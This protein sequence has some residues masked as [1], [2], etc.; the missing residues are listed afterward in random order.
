MASIITGSQK[1]M[2]CRK[3]FLL[4]NQPLNRYSC[5]KKPNKYGKVLWSKGNS[6]RLHGQSAV[7]HFSV[8]HNAYNLR[9]SFYVLQCSKYSSN[10]DSSDFKDDTLVKSWVKQMREDFDH[11]AK[12]CGV[13][14]DADADQKFINEAKERLEA[15]S[16]EQ[17]DSEQLEKLGYTTEEYLAMLKDTSMSSGQ[18]LNPSDGDE[19]N[20][21]LCSDSSS[22][23]SDSDNESSSSSSSDDDDNDQNDGDVNNSSKVSPGTRNS[24]SGKIS[25]SESKG[26]NSKDSVNF[27]D[28]YNET[29]E[30]E[31]NNKL[32]LE[33]DED[34]IILNRGDGVVRYVERTADSHK[35]N[36]MYAEIEDKIV[37]DIDDFDVGES[38]YADGTE[39][40]DSYVTLINDDEE[41]DG[42]VIDVSQVS[43]DRN[44]PAVI[45]SEENHLW[46]ELEI[47]DFVNIAPAESAVEPA[48]IP[49][50]PLTRGKSGVFDIEELITL[51]VSINA[52]DHVTIRI[53]PVYSFSDY[54][55]IVSA[56]SKR[57]LK[58]MTEDLK[59]TYKQKR[60]LGDRRYLRVEGA[61]SDW[62]AMDIG[63]I[64]V[65]MFMPDEREKYD[66]ET[67]WTV[68]AEFDP[69]CTVERDPYTYTTSDLPWLQELEDQQ[70]T[71][72]IGAHHGEKLKKEIGEPRGKKLGKKNKRA[73]HMEVDV[74][75]HHG[76][77]NN[78]TH[79]TEEIIDKQSSSNDFTVRNIRTLGGRKKSW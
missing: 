7:M 44:A 42:D 29:N 38:Q 46:S 61:D 55:V 74:G 69:Q 63:N 65:H 36:N 27:L 34:V 35:G 56:K 4:S 30:S 24:R 41:Y 10:S 25:V 32:Q 16:V 17:G 2:Y 54:M 59:W 66:L 47:E 62:V 53:P 18:G 49:P 14:V 13:N 51:L 21:D 19:E 75:V 26:I 31:I 70:G 73:P 60:G 3:L 71:N 39:H 23:D 52:K 58:A 1:M 68:G 11:E 5:V 20:D 77:M 6:E 57:H 50:I 76:E 45:Q 12:A 28:Q 37:D 22:S 9:N 40:G 15:E 8:R 64:I 67:L 43:V 33:S 72:N 79:Q 48:W 78:D